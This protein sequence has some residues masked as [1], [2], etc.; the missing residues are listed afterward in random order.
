MPQKDVGEDVIEKVYADLKAHGENFVTQIKEGTGFNSDEIYAALRIL[1]AQGK[2][3]M[4]CLMETKAAMIGPMV[5][6]NHEY[7]ILTPRL[8]CRQSLFDPDFISPRSLF[9]PSS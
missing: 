9:A 8:A 4:E 3:I 2:L 5:S 6:L 1:D 7:S